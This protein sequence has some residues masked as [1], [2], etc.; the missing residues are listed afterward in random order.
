M[1]HESHAAAADE[2]HREPV[3][4]SATAAKK[5]GRKSKHVKP[6]A[7]Q[8]MVKFLAEEKKKAK[9]VLKEIR[10]KTKQ[11]AKKHRRL[12]SK[13]L[14]LTV[15]ELRDIAEMKKANITIEPPPT[16]SSSSS[17]TTTSRAPSPEPADD[18]SAH[19]DEDGADE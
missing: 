16:A 5:E 6:L 4:V 8:E 17:G 13:A 12:M 3:P 7:H 19:V 10:A 9:Q 18:S 15:E 1:S 11:E 2:E 14:R